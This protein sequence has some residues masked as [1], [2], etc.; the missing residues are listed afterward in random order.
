M[1]VLIVDDHMLIRDALRSLLEAH[2][3]EIVG[4]AGNGREAVALAHIH[5]P[6]VVLMDLMM[7]VLD[8]FEA[9]KRIKSKPETASIPV[10]AVTALSRPTDQERAIASGAENYL[11]KPFDIEELSTMIEHYAS[12]S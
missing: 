7:P 9:I 12:N 8:G 3:V 2:G 6:D 4:E 1:R 11:C 5:R 10:V